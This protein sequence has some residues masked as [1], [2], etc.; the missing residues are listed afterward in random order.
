MYQMQRKLRVKQPS[1]G[2]L[3][4]WKNWYSR[5]SEEASR[6]VLVGPEYLMKITGENNDPSNKIMIFVFS[7][8]VFVA[9]TRIMEPAISSWNFYYSC[10]SDATMGILMRIIW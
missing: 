3:M 6:K 4:S 8:P 10:I 2:L 5:P 9:V 1:H 7:C